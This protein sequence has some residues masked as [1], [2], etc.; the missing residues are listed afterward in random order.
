[1][2]YYKN[3]NTVTIPKQLAR[4]DDLVVLPRKEYEA[5]LAGK[6]IKEFTPTVTQKKALAKAENNL[7]KGKSLSFN[8]LVNKLGFAD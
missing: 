3:M 7:K 6:K 5:L 8:Q 4:R 2:Y 1:M